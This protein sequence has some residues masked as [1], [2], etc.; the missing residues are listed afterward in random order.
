MSQTYAVEAQA[1][2]LHCTTVISEQ[3]I[4]AMQTAG[5]PIMG[6]PIQGSSAVIGP[7][8]RIL[9]EADTPNEKLIVADLDLSAVVKNKTF[10]D[11]SGHCTCEKITLIS[12]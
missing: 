3:G 5:A 2:V 8:G 12:T 11:A 4:K 6:T 1:F 7:D 10:A 9:S